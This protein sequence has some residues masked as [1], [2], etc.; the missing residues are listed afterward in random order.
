MPKTE[1]TALYGMICSEEQFFLRE[2]HVRLAFYTGL[3]AAIFGATAVGIY[4]AESSLQ[5][6]LCSFA[7]LPIVLLA[8][9]GSCNDARE[10]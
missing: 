5:Y 6:L 9:H 3:I 4:R 1:H 7:P 2:H 8:V 10:T